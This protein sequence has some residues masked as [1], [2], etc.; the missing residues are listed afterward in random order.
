MSKKASLQAGAENRHGLLIREAGGDLPPEA[1]LPPA[2]KV[3]ATT[4]QTEPG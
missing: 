2:E 1:G 3:A 4:T